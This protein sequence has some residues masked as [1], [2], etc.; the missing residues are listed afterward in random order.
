MFVMGN[1]PHNSRCFRSNTGPFARG[2]KNI[3]NTCFLNCVLQAISSCPPF[4]KYLCDLDPQRDIPFTLG[5]KNCLRG[6]YTT[7]YI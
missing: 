4:I 6:K 2:L 1:P 3:G 7:N 5:L